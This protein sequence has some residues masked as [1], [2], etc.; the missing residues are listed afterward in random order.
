M[1]LAMASDVM[2]MLFA[3]RRLP[4]DS[5]GAMLNEATDCAMELAPVY[6]L[7]Q[8]NA[9]MAHVLRYG[10]VSGQ[11]GARALRVVQV[12]NLRGRGSAV[13]PGRQ[14]LCRDGGPGLQGAADLPSR[15]GSTARL[16]CP[17]R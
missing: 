2:M 3:V 1:T 11:R 4:S 13:D 15:G 17:P 5:R 16:Y 6:A 14:C 9:W 7:I 12:L 8:P 10:D